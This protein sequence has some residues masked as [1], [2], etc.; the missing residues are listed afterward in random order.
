MRTSKFGIND[1]QGTFKVADYNSCP[2]AAAYADWASMRQRVFSDKF[3][4]KRP[5]YTTVSCCEEWEYFSEFLKWFETSPISVQDKMSL[6]LD[7][8][9]RGLWGGHYSPETCTYLPDTLNSLL[10]VGKKE[11]RT[12]LIGVTRDNASNKWRAQGKCVQRGV[13]MPLGRFHTE[14]EA[15]HSFLINRA[16][17]LEWAA[18][19]YDEIYRD[20]LITASD[21]LL[22]IVSKGEVFSFGGEL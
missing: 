2:I 22:N 15:H 18:E 12:N 9:L 11:G 5:S 14:I 16:C 10:I 7:K 21:F 4:V 6:E 8:D 17:L 3:Q 1:L 19:S 13:Q 20:Y